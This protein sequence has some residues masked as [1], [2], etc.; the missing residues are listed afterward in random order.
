MEKSFNIFNINFLEKAK[1][2]HR[3]NE[4]LISIIDKRV[5]ILEKCSFP[6][7]LKKLMSSYS[8]DDIKKLDIEC[9]KGSEATISACIIMLNEERCIKRCIESIRNHVDEIIIV[10][11]GSTDNSKNIVLNMNCDTIKLYDYIWKDDFSDARN[12][13]SKKA[14]KDWLIH[15]DADE[16]IE[17]TNSYNLKEV[18]G[19]FK[20]IPILDNITL[21]PRIINVVGFNMAGIGRIY[22]GSS[23]IRFYG[24]VHEE[25]RCG[26]EAKIYKIPIN[27]CLQHDGY[28]EKIVKDK[29]K[30]KRNLS[31]IEKMIE[32]EPEKLRWTFFFVKEAKDYY[33]ENYLKALLSRSLKIE[34]DDELNVNNLV[35]DEYTYDVL[36]LLALFYLSDGNMEFV[37]LISSLMNE[38]YPENPNSL[39]YDSIYI[40]KK[41]RTEIAKILK[42]LIMYRKKMLDSEGMIKDDLHFNIDLLIATLLF[43]NH[44]FEKAINHFNVLGKTECAEDGI[45][46]YYHNCFKVISNSFN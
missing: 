36:N 46:K 26:D 32:I 29:N 6:N 44:N 39:Y 3:D 13:A 42:G 16:Y 33:S 9:L 4:C 31:L 45:Y 28:L 14:S 43:E 24:L 25:L 10:D 18:L 7:S 38:I 27:F 35:K 41:Y 37:S 12:Y 40:V 1:E 15:I 2:F 5:E 17:D 22:Y 21:C 34:K 23:K 30:Q 19:I 8:V 11:T 20:T